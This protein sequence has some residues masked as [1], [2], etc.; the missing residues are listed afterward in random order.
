MLLSG[1]VESMVL[2]LVFPY[3][4]TYCRTIKLFMQTLKRKVTPVLESE[5]NA[6]ENTAEAYRWC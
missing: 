3:T 6:D 1:L 2:H 5:V 4:Q